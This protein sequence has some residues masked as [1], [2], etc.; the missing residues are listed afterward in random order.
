MRRYLTTL[1]AGLS[2]LL[3]AA[4]AH[5]ALADTVPLNILVMSDTAYSDKDVSAMTADFNAANPG[6]NAKVDFVP[7][8]GLRDRILLSQGS[9]GAYDVVLIDVIWLAEFVKRGL[10]VDVTDR[11]DS[12][13]RAQ[14]FDG[15]WKTADFNGK[16]FGFPWLVDSKFLY[17]NKK[18]LSDA[19]F[20]APPATWDEFNA[21]AKALKDKGIVKY[22]VV[23]NWGQNEEIVC[24][25]AFLLAAEGGQFF[26][27]DGT[28]AFQ[29]EA[30]KKVL[31]YMHDQIASGLGNPSSR[32]YAAE[33]GRRAFLSGEAA[34]SFNWQYVYA[35]SK[36]PDESKVV[37][38]VGIA[39]VPAG[40]GGPAGTSVNGSMALSLT[41]TSKHPDEAWKYITFM[42]S[43]PLQDKF[44]KAVL[45]VWVASYSD[46]AVVAGQEE[47]AKA[48]EPNFKNMVL[49]PVIADYVPMSNALQEGIQAVLYDKADPKS[50]LDDIA[51]TV[52]KQ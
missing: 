44:A 17:Y 34:F 20:S 13:L 36:N 8:A 35:L 48:A 12:G 6:I 28:P 25:F 1:A 14:I 47:L 37:G 4:G 43:K 22:P 5:L 51:N 32:E 9:E 49:R 23:W 11:V 3:A 10:V 50:V 15:A 30:G 42:T 46:P 18:M 21:Q 7:Y 24:D 39:P 19:G 41:T 38:Q 52:G 40:P 27:A 29:Q 26:A 31:E 33:D 2:L 45:P 16:L